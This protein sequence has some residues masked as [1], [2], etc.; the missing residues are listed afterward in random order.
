MKKL[1]FFIAMLLFPLCLG[2]Q[3]IDVE[4]L[5]NNGS[6]YDLQGF[7]MPKVVYPK[8][9]V[10]DTITVRIIGDV[11]MHTGQI[12]YARRS[13]GYDFHPF[14]DSLKADLESATVAI[15]NMEFALGGTPYTGYPAFSAPDSY[16]NYVRDMGIDVFLTANNHITDKGIRGLK[17]TFEIYD[18]LQG[19]THAKANPTY[20]H[21]HGL[22]LAIINCTYGTNSGQ[23]ATPGD[24][25]YIPFISDRKFIL[26]S[27]V[28]A[29]E[30]G[31]DF[32]IA[33][34]HW[35]EEYKLVH[36]AAQENFAKELVKA[37][38]DVI[39][40]AH[41]H[42]VQDH[43]HINGVPVYYSIGNAVS[44]MSA[45][46]TQLEQMVTLTFAEDE[47]GNYRMLEPY[48]DWLWCSRPGFLNKGYCTIKVKDFIGRRNEWQNPF[49]YDKMM[50]TYRRISGE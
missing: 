16:A 24:P 2:A 15:A 44:N 50:S 46:N 49:D 34:P 1:S 22:K 25:Y 33:I 43:G 45:I 30:E 47:E 40:G 41:P 10:R 27:V 17:R 32:I 31:A 11:M 21:V 7:F 6:L 18:T 39:V 5:L 20:L 14:L 13:G 42:C 23:S 8:P 12:D 28:K 3:S 48:H 36:N 26:D 35:G 38:V 19:V 9:V 29:R 4:G 37:G